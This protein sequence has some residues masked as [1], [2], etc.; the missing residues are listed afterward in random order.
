M[1]LEETNPDISEEAP[2]HAEALKNQRDHI[3]R[4]ETQLAEKDKLIDEKAF[5]DAGFPI[6]ETG[7]G[8][9][10]LNQWP[11]G[12]EKSVESIREF[13]EI[14]GLAVA[15]AEGGVDE[16]AES[17]LDAVQASSSSTGPGRGQGG[18]IAKAQADGDMSAYIAAQTEHLTPTGVPGA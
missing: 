3:D 9:L 11:E 14:N 5:A 10:M 2:D 17:R 12:R 7:A 13:A 15:P 6:A 1:T 4:L 18:R 16:A 8:S